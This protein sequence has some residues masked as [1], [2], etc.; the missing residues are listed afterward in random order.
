MFKNNGQIPVIGMNEI[1][2]GSKWITR[3]DENGIVS[4]KIIEDDQ[5]FEHPFTKVNGTYYLISPNELRD[6]KCF[7]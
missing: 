5:L 4:Q 6:H 7:S 3:L 2:V 1:R